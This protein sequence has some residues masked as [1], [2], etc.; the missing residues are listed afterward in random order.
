MN[1]NLTSI[2]TECAVEVGGKVV[3]QDTGKLSQETKN[4]IN[5]RQS[6]KVSSKTDKIELAELS[7]LINRR[8]V[9]DVRKYNMKRIERALKNGGSIKA[10]KRKLGIGKSRM[11]A[12]RDKEGKT[13]N[14][15]G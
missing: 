13:T 11:N 10:V 7:K 6:L 1:D 5:K 12:L 3:R 14:Q 9:C 8:K 15:Y 2:I 4:L